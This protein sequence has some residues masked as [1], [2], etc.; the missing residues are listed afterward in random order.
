M[1]EYLDIMRMLLIYDDDEV[2]KVFPG[3]ESYNDKL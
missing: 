1:K 2:D 3:F